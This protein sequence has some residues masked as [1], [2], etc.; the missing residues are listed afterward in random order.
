MIYLHRNLD[1][2]ACESEASAQRLEA[3]G[4]VRCSA[5][6]HAALWAI[7]NVARLTELASEAARETAPLGGE[8][9]NNSD[10]MITSRYRWEL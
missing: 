9:D 10:Q 2:A 7:A 5:D 3:R 8:A 1:R 4:W 6:V